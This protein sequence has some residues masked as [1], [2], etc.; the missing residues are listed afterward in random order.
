MSLSQL[1]KILGSWIESIRKLDGRVE[2]INGHPAI[3]VTAKPAPTH[4]R[5]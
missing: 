4:D 3:D 1:G 5:I 2:Q